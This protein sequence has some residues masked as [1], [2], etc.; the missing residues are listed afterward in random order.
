MASVEMINTYQFVVKS[1]IGN[2]HFYVAS[3][4]IP[5]I[6]MIILK[7]LNIYISLLVIIYLG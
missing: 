6:C 3:R 4:P 1:Q 2:K 7:G 5:A